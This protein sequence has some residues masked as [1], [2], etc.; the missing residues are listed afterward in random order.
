M[1]LTDIL[2]KKVTDTYNATFT[3]QG[4][5]KARKQRINSYREEEKELRAKTGYLQAR[6]KVAKLQSIENKLRSENMESSMSAY[7]FGSSSKK[8]RKGNGYEGFGLGG[9]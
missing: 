5:A 3:H 4:Q 9:F 8:R 7:G 2:K 6:G 1:S